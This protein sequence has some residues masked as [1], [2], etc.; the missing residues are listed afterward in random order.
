MSKESNY[1]T[2]RFAYS[3]TVFLE[4]CHDKRIPVVLQ[5][6]PIHSLVITLVIL[7]IIFY[8]LLKRCCNFYQDLLCSLLLA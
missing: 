2:K 4:L 8:R 6:R 3:T 1:E 7:L 5:Y